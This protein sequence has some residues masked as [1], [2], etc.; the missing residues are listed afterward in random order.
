MAYDPE[1]GLRIADYCCLCF[2]SLLLSFEIFI[3]SRY[4][5][6]LKITSPY[7]LMFYIILGLLLI[8]SII[9]MLSRVTNSDPGWFTTYN[10]YIT[11]A[12]VSRHISATMYVL[13]GFVLSA[14]MFQL[15]CSLALVLSMVDVKELK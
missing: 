14:I 8:S 9:E 3:I 11:V 5:V 2:Y 7:I 4:L 10:N 6:P 15:S 13:L 1:L 12:Q